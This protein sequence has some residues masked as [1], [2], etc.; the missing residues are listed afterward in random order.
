MEGAMSK[1]ESEH[2]PPGE[3]SS[4]LSRVRAESRRGGDTGKP[5]ATGESGAAA[6]LSLYAAL[7]DQLRRT[8]LLTQLAIEFRETLEPETIVEQALRVVSSNLS[9]SHASIILLGPAGAIGLASAAA[10]GVVQPMDAAIASS[11]IEKGLAGW[12]VR[13]GSSVA[14]P[15]VS[16]DRRWLQFSEQHTAGS[17]LVLPIRQSQIILGVLTVHRDR[18][19]A[20]TSHDLLLM[21]GV[22]A[23]L[24]V[25]L[26]AAQHYRNE[27]HRREQAMALLA[28]SQ[29]LTVERTF[30][31]LAAIVQEK[32]LDIFG[33]DYGLL[34]LDMGDPVLMPASVPERLAGARDLHLVERIA[35]A[36]TQAWQERTIVREQAPADAA[37]SFMALPLIYS[38]QAIGALALVRAALSDV[39]FSANTW[40][41]LTVFTHVIAAACANIQL[42][43]QLKHYTQSLETLVDQRTHEIVISRDVLR[44]VFDSLPDGLLLLDPED[45]LLAANHAF[46]YGVLGRP[47][48]KIVGRSYTA[49]W[50][51]LEQRGEMHVAPIGPPSAGS[52]AGP[53][54][55]RALRVECVDTSG[56]RRW[57]IVERIPVIGDDDHAEQYLEFW[58][59]ES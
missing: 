9:L 4:R 8:S 21:E 6:D 44:I 32:S 12:A 13:H 24:G 36:A 57:Y 20:F 59:Q 14:L 1:H 58:R 22:T 16:R 2:P 33:V 18:P 42:V 26:S 46:C 40:S 51:E 54:K 43:I 5:H 48:H 37:L 10:G 23:Q 17:V 39:T 27:R 38:G 30:E 49:V 45:V 19:N 15:D 50:H 52:S 11:V 56:A 7:D 28:M 29:Y 31:D 53:R 47:P 41:L 55:Q 25:A 34:F 35:A 3:L